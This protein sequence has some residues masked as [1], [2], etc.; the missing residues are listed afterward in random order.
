[1]VEPQ[2]EGIKITLT[3]EQRGYNLVVITGLLV[4]VLFFGVGLAIGLNIHPPDQHELE[5]GFDAGQNVGHSRGY[6]TGRRD[7]ILEAEKKAVNEMTILQARWDEER[8][9]IVSDARIA[10]ANAEHELTQAVGE[11]ERTARSDGLQEGRSVAEQ[12]CEARTADLRESLQASF[13]VECDRLTKEADETGYK[14][15][16]NDSGFA[17][18]YNQGK[19]AGERAAKLGFMDELR[20]LCAK[21]IQT[22]EAKAKEEGHKRGMWDG[23]REGFDRG[24]REGLSEGDRAGYKRGYNVGYGEAMDLCEKRRP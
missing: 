18:G 8:R 17:N 20:E 16:Q 14:R 1:M 15:G 3:P 24:K 12:A 7:G 6:A 23:T 9:K 11:A 19:E 13:D 22:A 4:G 21:E 2:S 5:K 10:A